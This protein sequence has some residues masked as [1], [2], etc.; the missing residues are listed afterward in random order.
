MR[1]H[2]V[3]LAAFLTL[4][5]GSAYPCNVRNQ[6][7]RLEAS[8]AHCTRAQL[9]TLAALLS[10]LRM[11]RADID[12]PLTEST[13]ARGTCPEVDEVNRADAAWKTLRPRPHGVGY[14]MNEYCMTDPTRVPYGITFYDPGKVLNAGALAALQARLD[15]Q[16]TRLIPRLDSKLAS[17][18]ALSDDTLPS[19]L[20]PVE[21][22]ASDLEDGSAGTE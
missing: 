9:D 21:S 18:D 10:S 12:M 19:V 20:G 7:N 22:I 17:V 3:I 6:L 5:G 4:I 13:L 16:R 2:S 15:Y 1:T 14:T 11:F 8:P